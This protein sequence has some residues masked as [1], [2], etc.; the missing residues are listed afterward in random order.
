ML[1]F[2]YDV[3][4]KSHAARGRFELFACAGGIVPLRI[5][6]FALGTKIRLFERSEFRIFVTAFSKIGNS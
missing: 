3:V 1:Y 2:V 6:N 4:A 5:V